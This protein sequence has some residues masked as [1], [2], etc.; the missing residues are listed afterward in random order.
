[1]SEERGYIEELKEFTEDDWNELLK[2]RTRIRAL[3]LGFKP[4]RDYD[5]RDDLSSPMESDLPTESSDEYPETKAE[6]DALRA[7]LMWKWIMLVPI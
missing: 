3:W 4:D 6:P 7:G 1:M 2:H 5:T